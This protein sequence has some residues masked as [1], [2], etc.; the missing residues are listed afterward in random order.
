M[1]FIYQDIQGILKQSDLFSVLVVVKW[2]SITIQI[3]QTK[4]FLIV[5]IRTERLLMKNKLLLLSFIVLLIPTKS[6][7][8]DL[9]DSISQYEVS[10]FRLNNVDTTGIEFLRVTENDSILRIRW[11]QQPGIIAT[12]TQT[13]FQ[14][15]GDIQ[16]LEFTIDIFNIPSNPENVSEQ[17][18][19]LFRGYYDVYVRAKG[20][21]E[22]GWSKYSQPFLVYS[23]LEMSPYQPL[24]VRVEK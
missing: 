12:H 21:G 24:D 5:N 23:D 14:A 7:C 11:N 10:F 13:D 17:K 2:N 9:S 15:H 8:Q 4:S 20:H 19:K 16:S 18:V 3:N 22:N 6:F 1:S